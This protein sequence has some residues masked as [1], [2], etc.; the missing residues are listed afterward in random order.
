MTRDDLLAFMR[1]EKYAVQASVSPTGTP[2]SA[3]VGIAISDDFE[4]FFDTLDT[5]RKA[6]NLRTNGAVAFVIGGTRDGDERTVQYEGV[7][8]EP[9]GAD[10]ERLLTLYFAR[11]PEGR[12]RQS[13][14][15]CIYVRVKPA[16]IRY[17][18]YNAQPPEIMEFGPGELV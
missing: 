12:D 9:T 2:Q 7:A 16:W 5:S 14:P 10:L 13:W 18:N 15:G 8:D 17:S 6:K 1:F 4:I 11:F 3:V